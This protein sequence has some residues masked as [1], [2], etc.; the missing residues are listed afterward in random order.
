MKTDLHSLPDYLTQHT[1]LMVRK[2]RHMFNATGSLGP[3][4][5]YIGPAGDEFSIPLDY[6]QMVV[7]GREMVDFSRAAYYMSRMGPQ[8]GFY[9]AQAAARAED[10]ACAS[11][12][13]HFFMATMNHLLYH[14]APTAFFVSMP[15][16]VVVGR[17]EAMLDMVAYGPDHSDAQTAIVVVGRNQVRGYAVVTPFSVDHGRAIY[18]KPY[19]IDSCRGEHV[20]GLG[21]FAGLY[22][23]SRN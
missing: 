4:L 18:K 15:T 7:L 23:P 10:Q 11:E 9:A 1:D 12:D 6:D 3:I 14:A 2:I 22:E 17:P 8:F 13:R 5:S 20:N 19:T 16:V 21:P